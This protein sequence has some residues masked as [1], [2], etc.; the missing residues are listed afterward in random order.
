[1]RLL[2][3]GLSFCLALWCCGIVSAQTVHTDWDRKVDFSAYNTYYWEKVQTTDPLWQQRIKDAVDTDLQAKGWKEVPP[4]QGQV[5]ITAVGATHNQQ[6]YQTFYNGLGGWRW[7][8]FG[9]EATTTVQ[10]YRTGTLVLDMY[11]AKTRQLLWRGSASDTVS[12]NT[13]KNIKN[14]D[15]GVAKMF[16]S[17]PPKEAR[18]TS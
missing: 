18:K 1:M 5:A 14:L 2:R 12:Q 11:D 16:K 13:E 17:F 10:N 3:L 8:G 6:E 4:G 7:G 9:D 15:K